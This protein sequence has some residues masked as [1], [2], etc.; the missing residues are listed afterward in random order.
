MREFD[1]SVSWDSGT[2]CTVLCKIAST[3]CG[4]DRETLRRL[5]RPVSGPHVVGK[6]HAIKPPRNGSTECSCAK[7]DFSWE[8]M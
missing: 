7:M 4:N 5:R 3:S 8:A 1:D 6:T 2:L